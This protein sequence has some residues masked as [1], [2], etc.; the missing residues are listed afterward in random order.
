M[1]NP[2]EPACLVIA[3]ISGYTTYLA[4]VELDHAQDILA[5]LMDTVVGG[6]RPMFRLSKLEGDAAFTVAFTERVDGSVLQDVIEGCYFAFQRRLRDI[7]QATTCPC[8]ACVR[9]PTL[10]L[11]FVLHHG[12]VARQRMAGGEELVGRDVILVHRLLKNE[13]EARIGSHAYAL[14]TTAC[15]A[16]MGIVDP[17]GAGLREHRETYEVIGEVV[18]W[19]RDLGEAW[20]TEQARAPVVVEAHA[21]GWVVD[22][23]LPG[24]PS[25]VWSILTAP[26]HRLRWQAGI[27]GFEEQPRGGRRGIGTVNHCQH[28]KDTIIEEILDWQPP[29]HQTVRIRLP[30]PGAPPMVFTDVLEA[31][32]DDT[33]RLTMRVQRPRARKDRDILDGIWPGIEPS[34]REGIGTVRSLLRAELERLAT[35]G[36]PEDGVEPL[37]VDSGAIR[38]S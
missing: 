23:E 3:D 31:I 15:L 38:S 6:L 1:H 25:L 19:V 8:D 5:D 9:I 29:H 7:R 18:G 30:V 24:P 2:P 4:G 21:A 33:T 12:P 22:A 14:Y 36:P 11:K 10:D 26:E 28:G 20:G 16:A 37:V 27:T 17:A 32:D 35:V 34:V 13:V